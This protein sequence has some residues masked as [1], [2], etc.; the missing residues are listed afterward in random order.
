MNVMFVSF[1]VMK[2]WFYTTVMVLLFQLKPL[3]LGYLIGNMKT[4]SGNSSN[5]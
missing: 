1:S 5:F 3:L 2:S 4:A